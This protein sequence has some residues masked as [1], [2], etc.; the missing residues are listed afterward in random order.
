MMT[1][2]VINLLLDLYTTRNQCLMQLNISLNKIKNKDP[3]IIIEKLKNRR[4]FKLNIQFNYMNKINEF[5]DFD[6]TFN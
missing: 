6:E 1:K 2:K 5:N 3:N 4:Q